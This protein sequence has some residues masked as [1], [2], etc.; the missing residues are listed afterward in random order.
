M[1]R[2]ASI[3]SQI[4]Q[5]FPRL[6]FEA[7]VREHK[8]ERH[9]RGF[10]CWGQFVAMLF[11][12]L[13]RAH[14]LREICNG[15]AASEG[16]L[17]HLGLPDSPKRATLSYA[18]GH[19]PWQLYR[20]V[21]YQ[22][23]GRCAAAAAGRPR[24]FSFSNKLLL[25]DSTVV[26]LCTKLYNWA[27]YTRRKGAVKLHL[28]LDQEGYLPCFAVVTEGKQSD[29]SVARELAFERGTI[30][31]F[32]RGYYRYGWWLRL[33]RAGVWFVSRLK[34]NAQFVVLRDNAVPK[35]G[36]IVKDQVIVMAGQKRS[37]PDA[38]LRRIERLDPETHATLVFISN[39][40]GLD[41]LTITEIYRERWQIELFFKSL[42][43][44]LKIKSFVGTNENAVQIQIWTAL[45]SMLILRYLKLRATFGWSLSNLVALLRQQLFVHRPLWEWL[46][47]P[48]Q[49]PPD[50]SVTQL[51]LWAEGKA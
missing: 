13:G 41:A 8:G 35:G 17:R 7:L 5:L 50:I 33:T 6:E 45:V 46:N 28:I 20:A 27:N 36:P 1:N 42:K 32:D 22:L 16:K 44:L 10:T 39:H 48:F 18:N 24:K 43:Q 2:V 29:I 38:H 37:G 31:V 3:F 14:S 23:Y 25:I 40:H 4:L 12:Q 21:F 19:R 47:D 15:L 26:S 30:V 11:C 51:S 9:A 34:D 49:P